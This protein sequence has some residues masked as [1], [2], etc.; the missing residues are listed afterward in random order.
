MDNLG[1]WIN[2]LLDHSRQTG[3]GEP[4][5]P[6][7]HGRGQRPAVGKALE[8]AFAVGRSDAEGKERE[9]WLYRME[10]ARMEA[11]GLSGLLGSVSKFTS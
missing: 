5:Q 8:T 2:E 3:S 9:T 7:E 11:I 1:S 6:R 10:G 4:G